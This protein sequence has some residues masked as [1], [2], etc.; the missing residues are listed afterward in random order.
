MDEDAIMRAA[1]LRQHPHRER[2]AREARGPRPAPAPLAPLA[3]LAPAHL[4]G[5]T[6]DGATLI[7]IAGEAALCDPGG[8]LF[9]PA[10]DA[11]VVSDLHFEK[12]SHFAAAGYLVPPYDTGATL[13]RLEAMVARRAPALLVSLGD[14]FHDPDGLGRMMPED[15]DRLEALIAARD[16]VWVAGNH[17]PG[18]IQGLAGETV[19]ALELGRLRFV[20]EPSSPGAAPGTGG[21]SGGASMSGEGPCNGEGEVAGHLHPV[22]RLGRGR[23]P[24]R[25]PCFATDGRRMVMP[26]IGAFTGGLSVRAAPFRGLFDRTELV[27]HMLGEDRV[28][29][30][31]A[32][33]LT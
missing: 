5:R 27:A 33:A 8:G 22:A 11:L 7:E 17:D 29:P 20:H 28:Y 12:A 16:V 21:P 26:A 4:K 14:A 2:G 24:V 19:R 13:D 10:Y 32:A 1:Q 9:L 18:P 25:R 30:V 31:P 23:R 6:E 3:P 15:R